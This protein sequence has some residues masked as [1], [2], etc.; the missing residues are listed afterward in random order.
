MSIFG[1]ALRTGRDLASRPRSSVRNH[2][3]RSLRMCS[4]KERFDYEL[5][6]KAKAKYG[7]DWKVEVKEC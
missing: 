6:L 2:V 4:G 7:L 5:K 1:E 3:L